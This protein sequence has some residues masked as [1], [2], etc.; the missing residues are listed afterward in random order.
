MIYSVG[1]NSK[2]CDLCDQTQFEVIAE[3]DRKGQPLE[4]VICKNCGLVAHQKIPTER[5]L[6]DFYRSVYREDYHGESTPSAR[7]IMRAWRNGA[8][9]HRQVSDHVVPGDEVFEIGA[10]IGCTVKQF[11]QHGCAASGIEPH[12]GFQLYSANSVRAR[13]TQASLFD[14]PARPQHDLVL[15]VHVIEH[16]CSPRAALHHLHS[17]IRPGGLLYV[18]CPNLGAP[19]A[20]RDRLFHFAHIHNF[21]PRTLM[22][23]AQRAGFVMERS[24]KDEQDPCLEMLFRKAKP[25]EPDYSESYQETMNAL[26]RHTW[27]SYH[28]RWRYLWPRLRKLSGYAA[29]HVVAKR[30]VRDVLRQCESTKTPT[31]GLHAA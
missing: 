18:E 17:I 16:F 19:F 27:A 8:R 2:H 26:E 3:L 28:L 5:E 31:R 20:M 6:A 13:V 7:R 29:E 14:L 9:I 30:Y 4:T 23:M 1:A 10:G 11:E 12:Q 25:S 24:F 15:L 22:M 21:T